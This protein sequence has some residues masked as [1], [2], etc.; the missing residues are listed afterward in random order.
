VW[1]CGLWDSEPLTDCYADVVEKERATHP[2]MLVWRI[3]RTEEPGRLQSMGSQ[4]VDTST[5]L[6]WLHKWVR[7]ME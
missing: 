4:E 6:M 5:M 7:G 1:G 3:P 2:G